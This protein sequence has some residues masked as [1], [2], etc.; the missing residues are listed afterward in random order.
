MPGWPAR[1][2]A[3]HDGR[4]LHA[5]AHVLVVGATAM[6]DQDAVH[7]RAVS[8]HRALGARGRPRGD[9]GAAEPDAAGLADP[10]PDL[11]H[12][13]GALKARMGATHF[14]TKS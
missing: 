6:S 4:E 1:D 12:V 9:A 2:L 8:A 7:R 10:P 11:E 5:A 13:L 14:L 3:L